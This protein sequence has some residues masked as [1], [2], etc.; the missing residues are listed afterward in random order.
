MIARILIPAF[1]FVAGCSKQPSEDDL[2]KSLWDGNPAT[3]LKVYRS[4]ISDRTAFALFAKATKADFTDLAKR[5]RQFKVWNPVRTDTVIEIGTKHLVAPKD[6][7]GIYSIGES[8]DGRTKIAIWNE[9]R[10][11]MILVLATGLM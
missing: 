10:G 9:Q 2:F 3:R 5:T 6:F 11:E 7:L 8:S 1:I 4:E